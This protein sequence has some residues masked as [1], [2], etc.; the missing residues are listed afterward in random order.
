MLAQELIGVGI[1]D[2]DVKAQLAANTE[3]SVGRGVFGSPSFFVGNELFFGKDRLR[4]VEDE[5]LR[6]GRSSVHLDDSA[7]GVQ[8]EGEQRVPV[9]IIPAHS[10]S[11][12]RPGE[13]LEAGLHRPNC[14]I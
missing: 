8:E 14:L 9:S 7:R 1:Q 3:E 13:L 4:E 11:K 5:I 12:C 2:P 6:W 10:V